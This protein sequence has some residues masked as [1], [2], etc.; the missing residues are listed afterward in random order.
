MNLDKHKAMGIMGCSDDDNDA[1]DDDDDDD[2]VLSD[3]DSLE[4]DSG[5]AVCGRFGFGLGLAS[6]SARL[7]S[8]RG[9]AVEPWSTPHEPWYRGR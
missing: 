8:H 2:D 3:Y 9:Y 1:N 6:R 4:K 7:G 5:E